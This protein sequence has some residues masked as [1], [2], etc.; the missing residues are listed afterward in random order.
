MR[1]L[2]L[3]Q[4]D[5]VFVEGWVGMKLDELACR[6]QVSGILTWCECYV[7]DSDSDVY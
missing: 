2:N 6:I 5:K 4:L 1:F 7:V 3:T